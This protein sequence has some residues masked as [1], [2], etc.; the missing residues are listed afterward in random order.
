MKLSDEQQAVVD[1][2]ISRR[3]GRLIVM[4]GPAGCGKSEIVNAISQ[5]VG[6]LVIVAPTGQA[7]SIIG[8]R[9]IHRAFGMPTVAPI[10][11]DFKAVSLQNQR[12]LDPATKFFGGNSTDPLKVCDWIV[13]DE[14]SM[15]RCD[16]IDGVDEAMKRIRGSTE[17]FGGCGVLLCGDMGQAIPVAIGSD[18]EVLD[19]YGYSFPYG[20]HQSRVLR[21]AKPHNIEL[22]RIWRQKCA[23]EA[24]V[25]TRVRSGTQTDSDL[26]QINA[27]VGEPDPQ[28]VIISPYNEVVHYFNKE[29]LSKLTSRRY[30]FVAAKGGTM[31]KKV[32]PLPDEITLAEGCRVIIKS[33]FTDDDGVSAVN[34]DV[35]VFLGMENNKLLVQLDRNNWTVMVSARSTPEV[36]WLVGADEDGDVQIYTKPIGK[37][38]QYPIAL[39]YAISVHASQGATIERVHLYLPHNPPFTYSLV[40]VGLS[41]ITS[42]SGL[43]LNREI[44]SS[45]IK[46]SMNFPKQ[47]SAA[48]TKPTYENN[49]SVL[50]L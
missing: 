6:R 10:N 37:F 48:I 26:S 42:F 46:S 30:K 49:Q 1:A 39:G 38:V 31:K 41:R 14:W 24:E 15:I 36:K 11:P 23:A 35:G 50:L 25:L 17:P 12:W 16:L 43:T 4:N 40:Y 18:A 3:H 44:T 33:N 34:G 2:V 5:A 21:K 22:T 9:T 13:M 32:G 47:G 8:G 27:R 29:A 28:A 7:A 45:D 19:D 20:I